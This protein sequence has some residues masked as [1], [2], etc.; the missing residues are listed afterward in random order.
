MPDAESFVAAIAANPADDLPRL[1]FADWLDE[2]G[3][4][5]RAGF[6]RDHVRLAKLRP[7]TDE[8]KAL[9]RRCAD[10]LRAN[11]PAWIQPACD[12]FGQP[13]EW[14]QWK[15]VGTG[16][17]LALNPDGPPCG[18]HAPLFNRGFIERVRLKLRNVQSADV[19]R[20]FREHPITRLG[21][22]FTSVPGR[23]EAISS[24]A[25]EAVRSLEIARPASAIEVR[26]ALSSP[27]WMRLTH[28]ST[29]DPAMLGALATSPLAR[30]LIA[31]R[32]PLRNESLSALVEYPLDDRLQEFTLYRL[33][34]HGEQPLEE[35]SALS[36]IS[37]RPTLKRLDLTRC[38]MTDDGLAAFARG[39]EWVRLQGLKLGGNLFGDRGWR[40][41][42]L[43]YLDASRNS[44]TDAGAEMLARSGMLKT[45]RVI[46]LRGNRVAGR[47]AVALARAV[48]EGKL[49]KLLLDGNPLGKRE[50]TTVKR[51][52]GERSDI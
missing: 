52:L 43:T 3:D 50:T 26:S 8:Y 17:Q 20:L 5:A 41:P 46:D 13:A 39:E 31:L 37:F 45:L 9:F 10:T 19:A 33:P 6:I 44:L 24:P 15:S 23:W 27:V 35:W 28:V 7:G 1:V 29:Y 36:R 38:G 48:A 2:N 47:G 32:V 22:Q 11:L 12:A 21:V 51:L 40:T 16:F 34:P 4:P 42:E 25:L 14:K 30:R 49:T 18:L